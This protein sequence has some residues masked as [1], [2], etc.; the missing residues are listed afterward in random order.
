MAPLVRWM[1]SIILKALGSIPG[2][3]H[4]RGG[5]V[6]SWNPGRKERQEGEMRRAVL[7]YIVSLRQPGL[8]KTL[9]RREKKPRI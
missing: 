4:S 7:G 2:I 1:P 5:W 3:T 6:H 8:H 9:S